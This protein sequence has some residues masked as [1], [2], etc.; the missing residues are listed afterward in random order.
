MSTE[1]VISIQ[2]QKNDT[3]FI[4]ALRQA[5]SVNPTRLE[6]S[7]F[8]GQSEIVTLLLTLTPVL[9]ALIGKVIT[10]QIRARKHIKIVC[11]GV[12]IQGIDE[13]NAAQILKSLAE[14]DPALIEKSSKGRT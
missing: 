13:K 14:T 12:Q 11:R 5:A 4:E 8:D 7:S 6:T 1:T 10:E 3:A 2:I 9:A